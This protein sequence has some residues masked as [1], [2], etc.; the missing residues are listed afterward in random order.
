LLI[1][2]GGA[3]PVDDQCGRARTDRNALIPSATL[4]A[5]GLPGL[6][7]NRTEIRRSRHHLR[8]LSGSA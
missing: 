1:G 2:R 8:F 4:I 7:G 6:P 5:S 3:R